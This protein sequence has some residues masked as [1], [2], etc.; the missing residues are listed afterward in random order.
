MFELVEKVVELAKQKLPDTYLIISEITPRMDHFDR[1]VFQ[2][3]TRIQDLAYNEGNI[4]LIRHNNLRNYQ[5]MKDN[6]HVS[7]DLGIQ[8]LAGNLKYGIRRAFGI[9]SSGDSRVH[10]SNRQDWRA[11]APSSFGASPRAPQSWQGRFDNMSLNPHN[12][13][14]E[15]QKY[16]DS[17][18]KSLDERIGHLILMLSNGQM[19]IKK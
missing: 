17:T 10:Y 14:K 9:Q 6:K 12:Y 5:S 1:D 2:T 4:T 11:S 16:E 18:L 13:H 7:E 15:T 3:N 19:P 8:K